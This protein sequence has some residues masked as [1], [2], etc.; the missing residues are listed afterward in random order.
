M[1]KSMPRKAHKTLLFGDIMRNFFAREGCYYLDLWPFSY[2]FLMV[3]SPSIAS[4]ATHTC[5]PIACERP[6]KLE[7]FFKPLAGGPNL[8][9]LP[10]KDW[11][12]W[13]TIFNKGFSSDNLH[14]F[15]PG[16]VEETQK[17]RATLTKLVESGELFHLDSVTLRF[18]I[19]FIGRTVL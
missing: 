12:P 5:T 15:V 3:V 2:P 1:L 8:F 18:T 19:D 13:R 4:Q 9:D 16:M 10:E 11:K 14:S 7:A 6:A 17:Y